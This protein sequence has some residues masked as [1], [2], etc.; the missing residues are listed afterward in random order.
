M[1]PSPRVD[2]PAHAR[3]G[4][5]A[6]ATAS[7]T[8]DVDFDLHGFVAVRLVD[9]TPG[10]VSSVAAQ[11]GLMPT[12]VREPDIV[13]RFVERLE[14][15]SPVQ[16]VGVADAAFTD[17]AF[18]VLRGRYKTKARVRVPLDRVGGSCE[19][20]CERGGAGVPLLIAIVN[21]TAL[22][23][24]FLPLHA[25]AFEYA[26]T[27]VVVTGWTKGG[28]TEAL[29]AFMERGARYIADE[30]VYVAPEADRVFGIPEPIRL[31]DWHLRQLSRR[32]VVPRRDR[33]RMRALG[34]VA[35]LEPVATTA[36]GRGT[37]L[38]RLGARSLPLVKRQLHADIE[39]ERLFS[40]ERLLRTGSFDRL[41]FVVSHEDPSVTVEPVDAAD[42]AAR[43]TFSLEHERLDLLDAYLK[44][45]F[46]FP[47][48]ANAFLDRADDLER[49]L[50]EK[51]L[52]G[53]QAYAVY[54]PFPAPI[55]ALFDAIAPVL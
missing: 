9:P 52:R 32:D 21:L 18:L 20:V 12:E 17:D 10:E 1:T 50:L 51:A 35:A 37:K 33:A 46:A 39:P 38:R 34:L 36:R 5:A 31:W 6:T 47:D 41:F 43:M 44:F 4:G 23:K 49:E 13:I 14:E 25:S 48:A 30:W 29:L 28:K 45:R 53:K 19:I 16:F 27:G 15:M 26:G 55:P 22:A 3:R 11:L 54:H 8:R 24:G 2:L 42:V 40:R 7:P